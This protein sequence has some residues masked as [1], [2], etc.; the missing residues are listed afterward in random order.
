MCGDKLITS[1]ILNGSSAAFPPQ[2]GRLRQAR[3]RIIPTPGGP[4]YLVRQPSILTAI[5]EVIETALRRGPR[6]WR[7][8]KD[9]DYPD[10]EFL[11]SGIEDKAL[12]LEF[13]AIVQ[14]FLDR[15]H[16]NPWAPSCSAG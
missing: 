1:E 7:E 14:P 16:A 4:A 3:S 11:R 12:Y 8:D 13:K 10:E 5:T 2:G 6:I 15:A 9:M